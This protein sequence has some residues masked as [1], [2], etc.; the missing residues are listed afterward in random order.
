MKFLAIGNCSLQNCSPD[1]IDGNAGRPKEKEKGKQEIC[2][3]ST[4]RGMNQC[5]CVSGLKK[6]VTCVRFRECKQEDGIRDGIECTCTSTGK[7]FGCECEVKCTG[8]DKCCG[9]VC[10]G[11][12]EC[13][14]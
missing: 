6:E 7:M 5:S 12:D 1:T 10:T 3:A 13:T 9:C 14:I 8:N 11:F 4:G 2:G